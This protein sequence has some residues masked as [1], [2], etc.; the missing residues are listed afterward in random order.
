MA[1]PLKFLK[2]FW[3]YSSYHDG[4]TLDRSSGMFERSDS[5]SRPPSDR[6]TAQKSR[7][8]L[9]CSCISSRSLRASNALTIPM[10][11]YND[12]AYMAPAVRP[13][14]PTFL[15]LGRVCP[16]SSRVT[17]KPFRTAFQPQVAGVDG[18]SRDSGIRRPTPDTQS[19]LY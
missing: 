11:G 18:A 6:S 10:I 7:R 13:T 12:L 3:Q 16:T 17:V 9:C 1:A 8:R 5:T 4:G 14:L 15:R 19:C 2:V